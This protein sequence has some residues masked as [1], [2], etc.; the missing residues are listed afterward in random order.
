M[1]KIGNWLEA[2]AGA[3]M[4]GTAAEIALELSKKPAQELPEKTGQERE[5]PSA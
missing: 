5:D 4:L 1:R 3:V 2:A